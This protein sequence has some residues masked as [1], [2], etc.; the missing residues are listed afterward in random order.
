MEKNWHIQKLATEDLW[1]LRYN[2]S[3]FFT[4]LFFMHNLWGT[5]LDKYNK[6]YSSIHLESNKIG[7]AFFR[8]LYDFLC[9]LEDSAKW[10]YYLGCRFARK[11]PEVLRSYD[12]AIGLRF[13][14][15]KDLGL[16]N[17]TLG[18]RPT[19]LRPN[20]GEPAVGSDRTRRGKRS[21][22][23]PGSAG[24]SSQP[25]GG[26]GGGGG[27]PRGGG[28]WSSRSGERSGRGDAWATRE[29]AVVVHGGGGVLTWPVAAPNRKLSAAVAMAHGGGARH[30][31]GRVVPFIGE[32][33]CGSKPSWRRFPRHHC[34]GTAAVPWEARARRGEPRED[35]RSLGGAIDRRGSAGFKPPGCACGLGKARARPW[36]RGGGARRTRLASAR[37]HGSMSRS[38]VCLFRFTLVWL[39]FSPNIWIEVHNVANR[40]VVDLTTLYNFYRG[41]RVFFSTDFAQNAAKLWKSPYLSEQ[42]LLS[43]DHV[44]IIL[45]PKFEM[46]IYMK[47]VS[48]DELDNFHIGRFWSV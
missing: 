12:S 34:N 44:F 42:G 15:Q 39:R 1:I 11:S 10:L 32:R 17:W 40:K 26:G 3:G 33:T 22:G 5:S 30:E 29:V 8:M 27:A 31:R 43:V 20:S 18:H 9:I 23:P 6:S 21:A 28:R 41:S 48:V 4:F 25:G 16:R 19:A 24:S 45:H 14:P 2:R 7:F 46:P 35:R 36:S 37:E 47:V 38:D 13:G